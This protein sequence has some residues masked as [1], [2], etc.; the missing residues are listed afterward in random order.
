MSKTVLVCFVFLGLLSILFQ[1][2]AQASIELS[3]NSLSFGNV[4]LNTLAPQVRGSEMPLS[5]ISPQSST[6][7]SVVFLPKATQAYT[8]SVCV[9]GHNRCIGTIYVSGAGIAAAPAATYVFSSSTSN[10][11]FGSTFVGTSASRSITLTSMGTGTVSVSQVSV[12]ST[13]FAFS[14]SREP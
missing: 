11:A 13:A 10:L 5:T 14:V 2:S 6:S 1:A 4:A 9:V 7:F 8:G 3:P 12:S